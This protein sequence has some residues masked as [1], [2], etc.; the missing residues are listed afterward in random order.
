MLVAGAKVLIETWSV[1]G[2]H[3]VGGSGNLG[4]ASSSSRWRHRSEPETPDA[5]C[6]FDS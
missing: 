6:H 1:C 3:S 2:A 5:S 4:E